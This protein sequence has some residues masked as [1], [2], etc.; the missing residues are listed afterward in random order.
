MARDIFIAL[1]MLCLAA[2]AAA[3][4]AQASSRHQHADQVAE[5]IHA[6]SL[7]RLKS[8]SIV[9]VQRLGKDNLP[10]QPPRYRH[11]PHMPHLIG[12]KNH[13]SSLS[14]SV[15][16]KQQSTLVMPV[17]PMSEASSTRKEEGAKSS[18][19]VIVDEYGQMR[20]VDVPVTSRP[21]EM[22][23]NQLVGMEDDDGLV[24]KMNTP[25]TKSGSHREAF[26]TPV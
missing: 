7:S 14:A 13:A 6:Q 1:A 24:Q 25:L 19:I 11:P 26:P 15:T 16:Q 20:K 9:P 22:A 18:A 12:I 2:A 5:L 8:D 10:L 23:N 17:A 21:F 3:A 4:A